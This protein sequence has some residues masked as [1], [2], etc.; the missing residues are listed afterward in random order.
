MNIART[1]LDLQHDSYELRKLKMGS[2]TGRKR[3]RYRWNDRQRSKERLVRQSLREGNHPP[4]KVVPF[5][6]EKGYSTS[7]IREECRGG[8]ESARTETFEVERRK[9]WRSMSN[10]LII[11]GKCKVYSEGEEVKHSRYWWESQH[12]LFAQ[13]RQVTFLYCTQV[14]YG[15]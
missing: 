8:K 13:L 14:K 11:S 4:R 7:E 1:D 9:S 10:C 6:K 12:S 2:L 5:R 15:I 3:W